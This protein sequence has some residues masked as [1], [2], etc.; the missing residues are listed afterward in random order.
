ME[1]RHKKLKDV[2]LPI[3]K[4]VTAD[5]SSEPCKAIII[6]T[7]VHNFDSGHTWDYIGVPYPEGYKGIK[8]EFAGSNIYY[9]NHYDIYEHPHLLEGE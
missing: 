5:I 2:L 9:F 1:N 3:G 6:G 8:N 4:V 7:R